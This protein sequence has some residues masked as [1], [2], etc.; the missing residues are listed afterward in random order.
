MQNHACMNFEET[1]FIREVI[2]KQVR[3]K[4][5]CF[6]HWARFQ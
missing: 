4:N 6:R 3:S 5:M 1:V 2:T